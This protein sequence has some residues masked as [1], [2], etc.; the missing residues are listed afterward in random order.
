M[1]QEVQYMRAHSVE[2]LS[3]FLDFIAIE[4]MIENVMMLLKGTLGC[5]KHPHAQ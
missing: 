2:P 1:V 3:T 5:V 4:Y